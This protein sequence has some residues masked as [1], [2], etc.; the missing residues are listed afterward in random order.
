MSYRKFWPGNVVV[1]I[2]SAEIPSLLNWTNAAGITLRN[3]KYIDDLTVCVTIRKQDY[4]KLISVTE[5]NGAK[6]KVKR[7]YGFFAQ[8]NR[9]VNRPILLV[10]ALFLFLMSCYIPSR[11]FFLYV[12]GNSLVPE[13]YILEIAAEC[14]IGFGAKRRMIRSEEMKNRLLERI[15]QLQWAGINTSG[16]TA[17]ISVREKTQSEEKNCINYKVS[18]IVASIDGI[19]QSCTVQQGDALCRVGQAVR[20]G[21]TLVS[22][23][24]DCGIV[25]KATRANAEIKALTFRNLEVVSPY[26]TAVKV[27]KQSERTKYSIRIGKKLIKLFKDSGNSGTSCGKIYSEEYIYL[28]GGFRLPV[29]IIKETEIHFDTG[30]GEIAVADTGEWLKEFSD[31]YLKQLMISGEII[32]ADTEIISGEDIFSLRGSYACIEMIGQEKYEEFIPKDDER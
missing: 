14:G 9:L 18:S 3:I 12:E 17:V 27:S 26:S 15:P 1:E 29:A 6:A 16:C 32:S 8:V 21:Q 28:P 13:K 19:I 31:K 23:Y 22:G 24:T 25:T 5:K 4:L 11:V 2:I 10:F 7:I 30:S 20:A